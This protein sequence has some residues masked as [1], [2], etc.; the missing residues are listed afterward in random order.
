[1]SIPA[2]FLSALA[3][4]LILFLIGVVVA[5]YGVDF[6]SHCQPM[7]KMNRLRWTMKPADVVRILGEPARTRKYDDGYF[8]LFYSKPFVFCTLDVYFDQNEKMTRL[9]HDHG[10]DDAEALVESAH[11]EP[12]KE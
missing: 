12:E 6:S 9:F 1:M 4:A 10:F 3:F 8:A 7:E 11:R 2:K 5:R